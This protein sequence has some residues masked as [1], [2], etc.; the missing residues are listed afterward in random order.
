MKNRDLC[1]CPD[2]VCKK[3]KEEEDVMHSEQLQDGANKK[4]LH[5]RLGYPSICFP[6]KGFKCLVREIPLCK[7]LFTAKR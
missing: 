1:L 5:C 4:P 3:K 2:D 6:W 7:S